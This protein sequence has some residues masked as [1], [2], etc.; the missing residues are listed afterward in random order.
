MRERSANERRFSPEAIARR[1]RIVKKCGFG[2][3]ILVLEVGILA[4]VIA[5]QAPP[6]ART[7][8]RAGL[9]AVGGP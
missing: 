2:A 1:R 7:A 8:A 5:G 3:A 6:A 4:V 9:T